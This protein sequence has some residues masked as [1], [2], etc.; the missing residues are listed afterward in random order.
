MK[1]RNSQSVVFKYTISG[2]IIGL[3]TI[4]FILMVD[5]YVKKI[6][7]SEIIDLHKNNPVYLI[8]DLSPFFIAF[9]AYLLSKKYIEA[10]E[11]LNSKLKHEFDKNKKIF[12]FVEKIRIGE[13]NAGYEVQG[14]DDVLGQSI[15][16]LRD[17]L[18]KNKEEEENRRKIDQQ[19]NWVAEGL[20]TFGEI[21]RKDTDN[22]EELTYNLISTLVKYINANQGA[23]FVIDDEVEADKH[24]KM[25]ACYAYD[26]RKFADKR[27]E[28]GDGI[29]GAAIL[30]QETIFVTDVPK[31]YVHITSGLGEAT[32]KCL[33]VVPLKFNDY[34][35]GVIEIGAF[36]NI[37]KYIVEFV[38]K[39]AESVGSTI[40]NVKINTRTAKLLKE[41]RLQAETLAAQE[42]QMRQ[43]MEEL[44]ATQEE[45]ARQSE[46]F[47][48]F[49]NSVNHTLIRAEYENDGTL[50]YAN[51][52]FLTKLGYEKNSEV[53]GKNI[54][55]FIDNKDKI[56]F[57]KLWDSLANGGKHFEGD[58]KHITKQGR[59]L[60]TMSTYT[61]MRRDD[62]NVEKI[63][64]LA[65]D[66]TEQKKQSL[67]Y[68]G[69]INALNRSS[70]K[71]D[72]LPTGDVL[73]CNQKFIDLMGYPVFELKEKSIFDF[74]DK[75]ELN[76]LRDIWD[77]VAQGEVWEGTLKQRTKDSKDIWVR[78]SLSAVRDMYNDIAKIIC[79]GNDE[80]HEKLMEIETQKQTELL[81]KH[82]E[83][84]NQAKIDLKAQLR[85][86]REDVKMQF[87][88]I[89]K[90]QRR[91]ELTLQGASDAI[92]TFDQNGIVKFFNKAAS[93]LWEIEIDSVIG[94]NIKKLFPDEKYDDEFISSL[95][96]SNAE[97]IVGERKEIDI[98]NTRGEDVSVII[99]LSMA[100][101][102]DETSYTAFIQ[103][104]SVDF[105]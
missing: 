30:E 9:C 2:F 11:S 3:L 53:E 37:D 102:E 69:Q 15:L 66:T 90:V 84:L 94:R 52:K 10:T 29:I 7:F 26:R 50:I 18:K 104:I 32:P 1:E 76:K 19:S 46:K 67:D 41:S 60:W 24:L 34:V 92:I 68:L 55:M 87:K 79:I 13:I 21:L 42:E 54:S 103:N 28:L 80:T 64:F 6:S 43:N 101:L 12:R 105:F 85:Q 47:V 62:G 65:I 45:A 17:N 98:K 36:H 49:T 44:Q 5:F 61:S 35:H 4:L 8:L 81:R 100:R 72:F 51:T 23:M 39:V 33:L 16:D 40:S 89:E 93:D 27:V 78:V 83:L 74:V 38:E 88:E 82:E 14:S 22:L 97:K 73:E 58:M 63:L 95:L 86:A 48:S 31:S 91:T 71:V 99:I 96:D 57:D 20:A 56:W 25:T 59:D 77:K 70:I 75:S